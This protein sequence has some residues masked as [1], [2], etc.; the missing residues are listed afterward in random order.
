MDDLHGMICV[1]Q[2][3]YGIVLEC[4]TCSRKVA[5]GRRGELDV[6]TAGDVTARHVG[7]SGEI[8]FTVAA[9]QEP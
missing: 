8:A 1:S 5:V 2:S 6:L 7:G 4:P 3:D 9:H